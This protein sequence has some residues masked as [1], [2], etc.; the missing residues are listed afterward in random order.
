MSPFDLAAKHIPTGFT[1]SLI[2]I[3]DEGLT[4]PQLMRAL[5]DTGT[6]ISEVMVSFLEDMRAAGT[7]EKCPNISARGVSDY[8]AW[9]KFVD[10][11]AL[12]DYEKMSFS[13]FLPLKVIRS[14][15]AGVLIGKSMS[16]LKEHDITYNS[17]EWNAHVMPADFLDQ[18][19]SACDEA[20]RDILTA[21]NAQG[22]VCDGS[23]SCDVTGK[24]KAISNL[25]VF[26]LV[27]QVEPSLICLRLE[28]R[29]NA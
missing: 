20:V 14:T 16:Y 29:C 19:I 11:V 5:A 18:V 12:S 3:P 27:L 28:N 2:T 15:I 17:D 25:I 24:C 21:G 13:H 23:Q 22:L 1:G 9:N 26:F 8:A 6:Q 7:L 4:Y 10:G